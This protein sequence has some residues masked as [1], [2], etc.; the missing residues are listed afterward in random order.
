MYRNCIET[1]IKINQNQHQNHL[2]GELEA[3]TPKLALPNSILS[4]PCPQE[5]TT[6]EQ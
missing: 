2:L 4:N 6:T 5:K 1:N 3:I